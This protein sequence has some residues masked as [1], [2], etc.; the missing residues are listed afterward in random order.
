L[1]HLAYRGAWKEGLL[2]KSQIFPQVK[3]KPE[4]GALNQAFSLLWITTNFYV[5]FGAAS[6][7]A[8]FLLL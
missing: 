4:Q 1:C 3:Q 7:S 8:S 6:T 5:S 2:F